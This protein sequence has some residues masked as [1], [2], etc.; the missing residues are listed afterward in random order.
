MK[1]KVRSDILNIRHIVGAILLFANGLIKIIKGSKDFY[2]L[3]EGIHELTQ[4]ISNQIFA[5]AIEEIDTH[6]MKERDRNIWEVVGLRA[7]HV[8]STFG[9]FIYRRRLYRNKQ[10]GET[11]FLL[12]ELLGWGSEKDFVYLD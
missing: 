6:L 2:E 1:R 12:D 4:R 10:T 9:E 3:E 5:W 11:K 8:V 7:K